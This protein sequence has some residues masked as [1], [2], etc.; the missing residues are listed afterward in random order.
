M[1]SCVLVESGTHQTLISRKGEYSGLCNV[2]PLAFADI[3]RIEKNGMDA[4]LNAS[5]GAIDEKLYSAKLYHRFLALQH[6][7]SV[8]LGACVLYMKSGNEINPINVHAWICY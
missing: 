8:R 7:Y 5:A 1:R 6:L 2:A 3:L 4:G